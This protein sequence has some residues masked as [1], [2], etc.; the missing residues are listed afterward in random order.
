MAF[1]LEN[2]VPWGRSLREYV[3]MFALTV[4][5]LQKNYWTVHT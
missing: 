2:V 3:A 5:D 4:P 1:E